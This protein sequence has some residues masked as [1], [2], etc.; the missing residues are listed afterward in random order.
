MNHLT[1]H[2][3]EYFP[4]AL[5]S[6][7]H[8]RSLA[9]SGQGKTVKGMDVDSFRLWGCGIF[10]CKKEQQKASSAGQERRGSK[11]P[12][13]SRA[14]VSKLRYHRWKQWGTVLELSVP[15]K[16]ELLGLL[17]SLVS[18]SQTLH[19]FHNPGEGNKFS[20]GKVTHLK[21]WLSFVLTER[22]VNA[23]EQVVHCWAVP[24]SCI[25]CTGTAVSG[26]AQNTVCLQ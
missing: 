14:E 23:S 25:A 16:T 7:L 22:E 20:A 5:F 18:V 3:L 10:T 24:R 8:F 21:D 9:A 2:S 19:S 15:Y 26:R 17:H 6:S 4:S 11:L 12:H 1:Q 13:S